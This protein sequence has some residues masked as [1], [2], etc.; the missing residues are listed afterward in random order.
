[1]LPWRLFFLVTD[2]IPCLLAF[3]PLC[4]SGKNFFLGKMVLIFFMLVLK[5]GLPMALLSFF[6]MIFKLSDGL[7]ILVVLWLMRRVKWFGLLVL[8]T[9]SCLVICFVCSCGADSAVFLLVILGSALITLI[10]SLPA[11]S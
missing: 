6:M 10:S 5:G 9:K 1:M 2:L 7:L 8:Q 3:M 11:S 4:N